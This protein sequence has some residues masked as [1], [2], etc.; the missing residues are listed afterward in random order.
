M[1]LM[2]MTIEHATGDHPVEVVRKRGVRRMRLTVDPRNGAVRLTLPLRAAL[3]PALEWVRSQ[4][5]WIERQ[6]EKLPEAQPVFP[7][8]EISFAGQSLTLDWAEKNPRGPRIIGDS[9]IVGGPLDLVAARLMR[10]L[11]KEAL[12]LLAAETHEIAAKAGVT[13]GRVGVGDPRTRWGSCAVN[14]DIRYSWRLILVPTHVRRATVAHE[15]AH[16]VHM[17]HSP[18]FHAKVDELHDGDPVAA[19]KWLRAHGAA[20]HWFGRS[21]STASAAGGGGAGSF[22][23]MTPST[24]S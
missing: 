16:R 14:G 19:R 22:R 17:D 15:V 12:T 23:P 24:Q 11:R 21:G 3:A 4:D 13:I 9:L 6:I 8:M 2:M 10:W 20:L 18:A 7:G 1:L 5:H